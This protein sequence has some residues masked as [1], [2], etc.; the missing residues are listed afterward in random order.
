MFH[1][2]QSLEN[3]CNSTDDFSGLLKVLSSEKPARLIKRYKCAFKFCQLLF[4]Y[5]S[6]VSIKLVQ[7]LPHMDLDLTCIQD[8][9]RGN[10]SQNISGGLA[11]QDPMT[12][13]AFPIN[14]IIGKGHK[15]LITDSNNNVMHIIY[16]FIQTFICNFMVLHFFQHK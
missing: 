13:I 15:C 7:N 2:T 12:D 4:L 16:I 1:T 11:L 10:C 6:S 3:A 8:C 14:A 9:T 5:A